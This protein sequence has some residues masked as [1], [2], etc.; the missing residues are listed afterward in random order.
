MKYVKYVH[1]MYSRTVLKL[2]TSV[3][4]FAETMG[5]FLESNNGSNNNILTKLNSINDMKD[6][7]VIDED[8][9]LTFERILELFIYP[10]G[11]TS[12]KIKHFKNNTYKHN[13]NDIYIVDEYDIDVLCIISDNGPDRP[14]F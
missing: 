1:F 3:E 12:A 11:P 9:E 2:K 13:K 7:V 10:D 8:S 6:T 5:H 14:H 4:K